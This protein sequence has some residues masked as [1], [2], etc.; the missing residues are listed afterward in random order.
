MQIAQFTKVN[1]PVI[2]PKVMQPE[3]GPDIKPETQILSTQQNTAQGSQ[4]PQPVIL[5]PQIVYVLKYSPESGNMRHWSYLVFFF[6]IVL[7]FVSFYFASNENSEIILML[8]QM[9]CCFS[10]AAGFFLDATYYKRK[11]EWEASTGQSNAG[12][13]AGMIFDILFGIIAI[14]IAI[15]SFFV[16][17]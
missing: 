5:Q 11:S 14:G 17:S 16:Y 12:S 3:V 1:D 6:G 4:F 7:Y 13:E 10:F 8:G 9:T 15:F 2:E